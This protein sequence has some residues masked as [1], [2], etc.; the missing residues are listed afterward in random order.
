MS[1]ADAPQQRRPADARTRVHRLARLMDSSMRLPGGFRIG[2]DGLI[3]LVPVAGDLAAAGVSLYIVAQAAHA[4][5][6]ARVLARM[7]LNVA[8]DTLVGAIPVLGDVFDVAF[9]ANLRN[10]RLMDAYLNRRAS[11]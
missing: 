9:K 3:G 6:P 1:P 11:H 5:V 10:A 2:V 7:V 8:L 4:G